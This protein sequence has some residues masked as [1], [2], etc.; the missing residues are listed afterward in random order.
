M[1]T[2]QIELEPSKHIIKS[3][4]NVFLWL[5]NLFSQILF[6]PTLSTN[7]GYQSKIILNKLCIF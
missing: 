4:N 1:K 6:F 3:K 7:E 5:I 2:K